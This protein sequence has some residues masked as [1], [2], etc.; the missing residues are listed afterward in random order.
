MS[1]LTSITKKF[2]SLF[3]ESFDSDILQTS[4]PTHQPP[5]LKRARPSNSTKAEE[6]AMFL[7]ELGQILSEGPTPPMPRFPQEIAGLTYQPPWSWKNNPLLSP[8]FLVLG[9]VPLIPLDKGHPEFNSWHPVTTFSPPLKRPRYC[10]GN[11]WKRRGEQGVFFAAA[12]AGPR[13]KTY[14]TSWWRKKYPRFP[15]KNSSSG[16]YYAK[17]APAMTWSPHKLD[18]FVTGSRQCLTPKWDQSWYL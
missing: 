7:G 9:G 10:L 14:K 4:A 8:Y 3:T 11:H 2:P 1:F 12:V 6:R 5:H 15:Q 18:S 16:S 13:R 17:K